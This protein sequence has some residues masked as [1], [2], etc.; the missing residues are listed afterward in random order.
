MAKVTFS[1]AVVG[2]A[3]VGNSALR[4]HYGAEL[5]NVAVGEP[6]VAHVLYDRLLDRVTRALEAGLMDE[7]EAIRTL[8]PDLEEEKIQEKIDKFREKQQQM[9]MSNMFDMGASGDFPIDNLGGPG[10]KGT[11]EMDQ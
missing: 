1:A 7:E 3:P 6:E 2:P 9:M 10:P 5:R 11:T 8:N 4:K